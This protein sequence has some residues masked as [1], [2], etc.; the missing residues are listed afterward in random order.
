MR[1]SAA[2]SRLLIKKNCCHFHAPCMCAVLQCWSASCYNV[3]V[4]DFVYS[5]D[6]WR[7]VHQW[8]FLL[9]DCSW[10]LVHCWYTVVLFDIY[11]VA[12]VSCNVAGISCNF[13]R[14]SCNITRNTYNI[15]NVKWNNS[16]ITVYQSSKTVKQQKWPLVYQLS[17]VYTE[18]AEYTKPM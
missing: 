10:R 6:M 17:H 12:R 8:S 3:N 18:S 1:R 11:N 15:T 7:L 16:V 5:A 9:F 2:A 4:T 14:V 13:A